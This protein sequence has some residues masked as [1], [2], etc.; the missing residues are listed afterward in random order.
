MTTR[1]RVI[2]LVTGCSLAGIGVFGAVIYYEM[3]VSI[4][5]YE[6]QWTFW[7]FVIG[8]GVVAL[9]GVVIAVWSVVG[10]LRA[11]DGDGSVWRQSPGNLDRSTSNHSGKK[12]CG[13]GAAIGGGHG[14]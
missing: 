7:E 6:T 1:R 14:K 13:W 12:R 11:N 3:P 5:F 8:F 10:L 9:V 4:L 2:L